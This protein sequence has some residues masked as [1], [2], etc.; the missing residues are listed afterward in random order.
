MHFSTLPEV[1]THLFAANRLSAARASM[2]I[3]LCMLGAQALT[4]AYLRRHFGLRL[5]PAFRHSATG[6]FL[7]SP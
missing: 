4:T 7:L 1:V 6:R 3:S 2:L 5:A